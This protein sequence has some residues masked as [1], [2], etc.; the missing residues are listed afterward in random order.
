MEKFLNIYFYNFYLL[1]RFLGKIIAVYLNPFAWI[2]N[3]SKMKLGSK[4]FFQHME[5]NFPTFLHRYKYDQRV[6]FYFIPFLTLVNLFI[7]TISLYLL[8]LNI[9]KYFFIVLNISFF[10][11]LIEAYT[12][13][14]NN[15]KYQNYFEEFYDTKKYNFPLTTFLSIL[16]MLCLWLYII[17]NS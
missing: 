12:Y 11:S 2:N 17:C 3:F 13:L 16:V 14:F 6:K 1:Y 4:L 5:N 7:I 8:N 9:A 15:N 10:L